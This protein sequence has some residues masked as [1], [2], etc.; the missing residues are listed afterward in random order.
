MLM[1]AG[2]AVLELAEIKR[3]LADEMEPYAP[4]QARTIRT[5]V[6]DFER[7][8]EPLLP[9]WVTLGDVARRTGWS[10]QTLRR[11]ARRLEAQ[12]LARKGGSGEWEIEREAAAEIPP[13]RGYDPLQ[14]IE[15]VGEL[16]EILGREE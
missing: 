15:D 11:R 5:L 7:I 1:G 4:E 8:V 13:R 9:A 14:E 10:R 16:A 6:A 12:G 3:Q 2:E